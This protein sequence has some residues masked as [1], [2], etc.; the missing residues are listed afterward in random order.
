MIYCLVEV[1]VSQSRRKC[2]VS[3]VALVL[4]MSHCVWP[5]VCLLSMLSLRVPVLALNNVVVDAELS[6]KSCSSRIIFLYFF[7]KVFMSF[8]FLS[9]PVI[10]YHQIRLSFF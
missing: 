1:S 7:Y 4:H 5:S 10:I 6:Y 9:V 8:S 3:Y 2:S